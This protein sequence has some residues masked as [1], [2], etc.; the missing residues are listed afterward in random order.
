MKYNNVQV[1]KKIGGSITLVLTEP[2]AKIGVSEGDIVDIK[3]DKLLELTKSKY[4]LIISKSERE[5]NE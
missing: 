1:V 4:V 5:D 3:I 2:L